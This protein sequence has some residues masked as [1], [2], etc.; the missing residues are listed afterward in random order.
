MDDMVYDVSTPIHDPRSLDP[1]SYSLQALCV[2]QSQVS[3]KL[4]TAFHAS[5]TILVQITEPQ[6]LL[7]PYKHR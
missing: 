2:I 3:T 1:D 4:L 7:R 5:F 6:L